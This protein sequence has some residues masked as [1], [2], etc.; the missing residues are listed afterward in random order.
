MIPV[1]F[2][3]LKD[4]LQ[5]E[6]DNIVISGLTEDQINNA[7]RLSEDELARKGDQQDERVNGYTGESTQPHDRCFTGLMGL[8][9]SHTE[10]SGNRDGQ[11]K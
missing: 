8:S 11:G 3:A 10:R 4:V 2:A 9:K 5:I 1:P 7:P 6:E